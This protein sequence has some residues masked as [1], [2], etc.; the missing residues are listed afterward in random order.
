MG[1]GTG[2][3]GVMD[4]RRRRGAACGFGFASRPW[5]SWRRRAPL[6][7][8]EEPVTGP[9]LLLGWWP[10]AGTGKGG[11]PTGSAGPEWKAAH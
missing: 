9:A 7:W 3:I 5:N 10:K 6:G 8:V 4:R 11:L 1:A 2:C